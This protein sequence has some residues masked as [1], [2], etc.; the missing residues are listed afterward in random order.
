[1]DQLEF[2]A[3]IAVFVTLG[4]V[5]GYL[6]GK[7]KHMIPKNKI[8][9]ERFTYDYLQERDELLSFIQ[10]NE[11]NKYV[12]SPVMYVVKDYIWTN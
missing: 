1:M 2:I 12:K 5:G 11:H 8:M 9:V 10:E 7:R 3:T 4:L 6:I